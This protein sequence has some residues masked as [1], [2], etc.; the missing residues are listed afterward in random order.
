M[1]GALQSLKPLAIPGLKIYF[2]SWKTTGLFEE[3]WPIDVSTLINYS[4]KK[5]KYVRV[6]A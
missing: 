1:V 6:K 4:C 3:T 2:L 5:E